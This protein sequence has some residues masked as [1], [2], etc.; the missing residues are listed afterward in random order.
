MRITR[1]KQERF[2]WIELRSVS[3]G[4]CIQFKYKFHQDC[5]DND[6]YMAIDASAYPASNDAAHYKIAVVNL[7]SGRLSYVSGNRDVRVLD[8]RVCVDD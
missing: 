6:C 3:K 7:K 4:L 2:D 1:E 8:A 5:C